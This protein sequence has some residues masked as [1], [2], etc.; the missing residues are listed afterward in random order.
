M[1]SM[2]LSRNVFTANLTPAQ[3]GPLGGMTS[4]ECVAGSDLLNYIRLLSHCHCNVTAIHMLNGLHDKH[5]KWI[6][7]TGCTL[8]KQTGTLRHVTRAKPNFAS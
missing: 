7:D 2:E 6:N 3:G 1:V 8:K 5:L 4:K